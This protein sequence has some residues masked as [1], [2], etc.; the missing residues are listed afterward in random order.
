MPATDG[1]GGPRHFPKP[2]VEAGLLF[3][4][5]SDHVAIIKDFK[6]YETLSTGSSVDPKGILY[7]L[8]LANRLLDLD[9]KYYETL[10][11]GSSVDPKGILYCLE[12][13]NR[14]LDLAPGCELHPQPLRNGLLRLLTSNPEL[15]QTQHSGAVWVHQRASRVSVLLAH[16]RK[17][18]RNWPN[19]RCTAD[20]T[21][22][23]VSQLDKLV[24]RIELRDEK[25]LEKEALP[26]KN[27]EDEQMEAKKRKR[28]LKKENSDVSLDSQGFPMAL[29]T[30]PKEKKD[31][32]PCRLLKR[33][34]SAQARQKRRQHLQGQ[35][36]GGTG[37]SWDDSWDGGWDDGWD[38]GWDANSHGYQSWSSGSGWWE[39]PWE[40][41]WSASTWEERKEE[42][43]PSN[44][45]QSV[46]PGRVRLQSVAP[47]QDMPQSGYPSNR[48]KKRN[49]KKGRDVRDVSSSPSPG[50]WQRDK[51]LGLPMSSVEETDEEDA[52]G[53][54]SSASSSTTLEKG[55]KRKQQRKRDSSVHSRVSTANTEWKKKMWVP[56]KELEDRKKLLEQW[57]QKQEQVAQEYEQAEDELQGWDEMMETDLQQLVNELIPGKGKGKGSTPGRGKGSR[58]GKGKGRRS[59]EKEMEEEE[60]EEEDDIGKALGKL[61]KTRDLLVHTSANYEEALEKVKKMNYLGK[62]AL[63]EKEAT[64]KALNDSMQKV[65]DTL[66]KGD[67]NKIEKVKALL[68]DSVKAVNEAREEAKELVQITLKTHSK[69]ASSKK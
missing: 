37:D 61:K 3:E 67:K 26:L 30:P 41:D 59:K 10:S 56:K 25:P 29:K 31:A 39:S 27:G 52:D 21:G 9:F 38:D 4:A 49:K 60:D 2:M 62:Q 22:K 16:L 36:T 50:G 43:D 47:D 40:R 12:L 45:E 15:N 1:R 11:T 65:K 46:D 66:V 63:K 35:A 17:L 53:A 24:K 20:L 13:A 19:P 28:S 68:V 8:E 5:F 44:R 42:E 14:L 54:T 64:F 32:G 34:V 48:A 57:H 6:Y 18:A 23:E 7:C 55:R 33:K 69:A 51:G 58:K